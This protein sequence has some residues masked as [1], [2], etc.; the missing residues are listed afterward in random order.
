MSMLEE[1]LE[2][3]ESCTACG[4]RQVTSPRRFTK[5]ITKLWKR[6]DSRWKNDVKEQF[7][8]ENSTLRNA[9]EWQLEESRSH[10]E[11]GGD[12]G[13]DTHVLGDAV[14]GACSGGATPETSAEAGEEG[15]VD[16][17]TTRDSVD[18]SYNF[19]GSCLP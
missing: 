10:P 12:A 11:V 5:S 4:G 13:D 14:C 6:N 3:E 7:E 15:T 18:C 9:L 8:V 1:G 17:T 16:D 2:K 19:R